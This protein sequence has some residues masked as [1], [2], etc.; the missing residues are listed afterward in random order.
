MERDMADL[1]FH[2]IL[3][4]LADAVIVVDSDNQIVHFNPSAESLLGWSA[5]ELVGRPLATIQPQ[6]LQDAHRAAYR[7]C[8][9]SGQLKHGRDFLRVPALTRAGGEIEVDLTAAIVKSGPDDRLVVASLREARRHVDLDSHMALT[10]YLRAANEA[11][12]KI[13]SLL[14]L[15]N[16]LQIVVD[17]LANDLAAALAHIWLYDP[18]EFTL[19]LRA[20]AGDAQSLLWTEQ[21]HAAYFPSFIDEVADS[22]VPLIR[23]DLLGETSFDQDWVRREQI[24][25]AAAFPLEVS[26]ELRGMLLYFSR[27]P[28]SLEVLEALR[29][30]VA[31]VTLSIR[32]VDS[33]ARETLARARAEE[34]EGALWTVIRAS[35]VPILRTDPEGRV[36]SW[37]P[38]AQLTLGWSEEEVMGELPPYVTDDSREEYFAIVGRVLRWESPKGIE[39]RRQRKDGSWVD[40]SL[41][42]APLFDPTG[43]IVAIMHVVVDV[44][45]RKQAEAQLEYRALHDALTDLPNRVLL[46]D[47][48]NQTISSMARDRGSFAL[49]LMDLN[50]FKQVNDTYGHHVGDLLLQAAAGRIRG[51]LRE[52]DTVA[53][54]G[55]DEFAVILPAVDAPGAAMIAGKILEALGQPLFLDGAELAIGSSIGVSLYPEHGKNATTLLQ[56]AD[57][58]MYA[59]KR[60]G[61]GYQIHAAEEDLESAGAR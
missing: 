22:R 49:L 43:K 9:E 37:N 5:S 23:S 21:L 18:A 25:S 34:A 1:D 58:A 12:S 4:G 53:R 39:M 44:T 48:L 8:L 54:L 28:M 61:E 20:S 27:L 13:T 59:A 30:Y 35:P 11:A 15:Q 42:A 16:V 50:R 10:K 40:L 45:E 38:S 51:A 33:F 31:M 46:F 29:T 3:D 24:A 6:H 32:D 56:H 52:S 7:R 55:G 17:S 2:L 14:D 26:G 57:S 60:T 47:R 19:H 36:T 41:S